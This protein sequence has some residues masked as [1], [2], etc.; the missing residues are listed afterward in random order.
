MIRIFATLYALGIALLVRDKYRKHEAQ[1]AP[2]FWDADEDGHGDEELC[3][4]AD[5]IR[6]ERNT[7]IKDL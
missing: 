2:T 4:W 3:P 6:R 5:E 7:P 1:A